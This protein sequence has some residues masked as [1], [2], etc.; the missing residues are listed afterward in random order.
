M[1]QRT[2]KKKGSAQE[3]RMKSA[4]WRPT[5]YYDKSVFILRLLISLT[6]KKFQKNKNISYTLMLQSEALLFLLTFKFFVQIKASF[7]AY[8]VI[9]LNNA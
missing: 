7:A 5:T 8:A 1:V 2:V 9:G 3:P 4:A 6:N